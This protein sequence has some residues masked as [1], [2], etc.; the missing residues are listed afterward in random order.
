MSLSSNPF[1]WAGAR[2]TGTFYHETILP[3]F[4]SIRDTCIRLRE[5]NQQN[6][7]KVSDRAHFIAKRAIWSMAIIG[8]VA[9]AIGLGFSLGPFKSSCETCSRNG[10]GDPKDCEG[11]L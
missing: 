10:G 2:K 6:M 1:L 7:F 5:I 4:L 3:A 11:E 8:I 9:I